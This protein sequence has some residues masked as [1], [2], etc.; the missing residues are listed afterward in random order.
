[1][2]L[3]TLVSAKLDGSDG[4][5]EVAT[6]LQFWSEAGPTRWFAKDA[7]FDTEFRSRF[8]EHHLAAAARRLDGWTASASG[9]LALVIL[10]DQFPRNAFRDTAHM[11]ATDPLAR[12]HASTGLTNGYD[13]QVATEM[14]L[15]FYLPFMHSE[16]I[17][18]QERSF[19]LHRRL[20]RTIHAV[21]HYEI[22]RRFG[23]FPHRN[24]VLGRADTPEERAFLD[25]GGFSG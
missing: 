5:F 16:N 13:E 15:F 14:R 4:Y 7:E 25:A 19:D 18:D 23:R 21:Q 22:I 2:T 6:I 3:R 20:G 11:Y 8:L 24:S 12:M 1:M 9:T 17:H 10:L